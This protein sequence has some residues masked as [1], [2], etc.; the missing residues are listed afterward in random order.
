MGIQAVFFDMGGTLEK[1]W[2]TPE[3]RL[4]AA[5]G[6]RQCLLSGGIDLG[7]SE[8][9]FYQLLS[10]GYKRYHRWSVVSMEELSPFQVWSEFI[11]AGHT[12]DKASLASVAEELMT[13]LEGKFFQRELRPEV[14]QVLA[15]I[16]T[17]GLKIGLISNICS[18]G[19]VTANLKEYNICNYFDPIILSSEYG[20]RKPDP[21]IFHYAA[22]LANV[23]TGA[24]AHVGDRIARDILGA[25]KAGFGLTVQILNDFDHGEEDEGPAPDAVIGNL[26]ELLPLLELKRVPSKSVED[27]PAGIHAVLFDAGDILY[28]RPDR[29]GHLGRFLEGLGIAYTEVP[30]AK[31]DSLKRKVYH[32]R[33]SRDQYRETFL[34]H[35]GITDPTQ[36]EHG[37]EMMDADDNDI[38]FFDGVPETLRKLKE[39]GFLLGII[40]DTAVPLHIKLAW[41]ERGGFG[42]VW[43][44]IISSVDV[45][46]QK[47]APQIYQAALKQLGLPVDQA[48]FVGHL[49]E[50]LD[51]ARAVGMKTIAFNYEGD[52]QA[53]FY[54]EKFSG[55]LD[56]PMISDSIEVTQPKAWNK[57]P[58]KD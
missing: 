51:G 41:F 1:V 12:Y 48:V 23:P 9:E 49:Q 29:G 16:R 11:L 35:L 42:D 17:M 3:Q 19:L 45:G 58:I 55:L 28:Y 20:R 14:S 52:A 10:A 46:I 40:T 26:K 18:H 50:E 25:R 4:Q 27:K 37:K 44:S 38:A 31:R 56:V 54:I 32:G 57:A 39:N 7:L 24:C 8:K 30:H 53:D 36:I 13:H 22:R 5:S 2:Y 33:I 15:A 21:A 43:D 47:P 34:R 6:L